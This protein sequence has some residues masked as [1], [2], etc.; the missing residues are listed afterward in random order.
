MPGHRRH[1]ASRSIEVVEAVPPHEAF[2]EEF[3][4]ETASKLE[5]AKA[6]GKLP[7]S[8]FSHPAVVGAPPG[9][10]VYPLVLYMD[11]IEFARHDT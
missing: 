1:D 4:A 2:F 3:N 5:T 10:P 11:G 9:V 6:D 8:Y 7:A